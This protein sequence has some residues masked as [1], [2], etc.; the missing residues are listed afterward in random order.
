MTVEQLGNMIEGAVAML[1]ASEASASPVHEQET[2]VLDAAQG[3]IRAADATSQIGHEPNDIWRRK[4]LWVDDRP[5]N[6]TFER[7]VFESLDLSFDLALSTNEAL[8]RLS[9]SRYGAII[10]DMGRREGPREGYR[11]LDAMRASGNTTPFFI[12]S[13]SNTSQQKQEAARHG[14]QGYTNVPSQLVEMVTQ[15]LGSNDITLE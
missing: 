5:D 10:S 2:T 4:I 11:L 15:A 7:Q 1:R 13:S 12:Y 3:V 9:S 8:E 14:A 6:N